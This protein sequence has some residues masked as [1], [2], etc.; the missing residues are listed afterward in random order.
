MR[1]CQIEGCGRP[2][3]ARGYCNPHYRR[4]KRTGDVGG[5]DLRTPTYVCTVEG[6][7]GEHVA[8]GYC[9]RHLK[10]F[11]EHG[12]PLAPPAYTR[13]RERPNWTEEPSYRLAHMRVR[14]ARGKATDHACAECAQPAAQWAYNHADPE[15]L[16]DRHGPYSGDPRFYDPLCVPCHKTRDAA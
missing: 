11:H 10:R 1:L 4:L 9:N 14:R 12:D 8:K 5:V 15:A 2:L 16:V 3:I 13:G 7:E 6:C